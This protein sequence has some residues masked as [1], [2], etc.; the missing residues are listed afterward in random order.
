[1]NQAFNPYLPS[2]EHV[3]DGEPHV[4]DGRLYVFGSHD[5]F[6]GEVYCMNPYVCWSAPV[7]DLGDWKYHGVIYTGKEDTRNIDG[8]MY[9]FAPDVVEN[10]GKYYLFY[11]LSES[12]VISVAVSDVPYGPYHFYGH[13]KYADG[14]LLGLREG[15]PMQF[16]P[17]VFKDDDGKI[18]LYTGFSVSIEMVERLKKRVGA[19]QNI[20]A[21]TEGNYV[22]RLKDDMLTVDSELKNLIPGEKNSKGTGYEGHEFLE[23]SS[24]R[25]FNGKYY[26]IYSSLNGHEL[27]YAMSDYPDK[28]FVYKGVLHSNGNIG[29]DKEPSYYYANNHGS[30]VEV[31]GHYYIFGHRHTNHHQY[32]R[33]GVA[34]EIFMRED[35]S[36]AQ[37]EMTSCG[38][39]GKPLEGRGKYPAYIACVLKSQNGAIK[40][41]EIKENKSEHPAITQ[42]GEDRTCNPDS[43]ITN[44]QNQTVIGYKYFNFDGL[45]NIKLNVRGDGQGEFEIYADSRLIGKVHVEPR[46]DF[47]DFSTEVEKVSG[48]KKAL[49][50]VYKGDGRV[51]LKWFEFG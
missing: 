45:K 33:Q 12:K 5:K 24:M 37:A 41:S 23:A 8:T 30:L 50:F 35:G 7:D 21:N 11:G 26:A 22:V 44:I 42:S 32:S 43:Y 29:I 6:N 13:V 14:T 39:N 38:L 18:Y 34:E 48:D 9:M 51:D 36:F 15:D 31:N 19:S 49:Y 25:K 3:P 20:E 2:W 4:Y 17:G 28:N 40:A 46:S 47:E 16:D 10:N 1:M 27:C